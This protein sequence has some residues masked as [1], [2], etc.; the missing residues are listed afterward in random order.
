MSYLFYN[1]D[2]KELTEINQG[3]EETLKFFYKHL[4]CNTVQVVMMTNGINA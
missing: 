4:D 2:T 3:E 1:E